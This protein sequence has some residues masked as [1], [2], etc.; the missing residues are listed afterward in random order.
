MLKHEVNKKTKVESGPSLKGTLAA[1]F[2]LGF[3][4]IF[5]WVCVHQIFVDRL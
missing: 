2:L 5:T 3:F 1:V 4:L